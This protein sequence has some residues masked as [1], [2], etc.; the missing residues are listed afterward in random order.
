MLGPGDGYQVGVFEITICMPVISQSSPF[1]THIRDSSKIFAGVA[2][3]REPVSIIHY[4]TPGSSYKRSTL[5]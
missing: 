2:V 3:A 5:N 4:T 1:N